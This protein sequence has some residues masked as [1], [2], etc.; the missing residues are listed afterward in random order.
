MAAHEATDNLLFI[1]QKNNFLVFF[2]K[3]CVF[4]FITK[5]KIVD[6]GS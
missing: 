6:K 2:I 4:L 3:W 1:K 5:I